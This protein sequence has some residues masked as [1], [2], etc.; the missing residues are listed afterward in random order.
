MLKAAPNKNVRGV[1]DEHQDAV[2]E[3]YARYGKVLKSAVGQVA[4]EEV[5][6]LVQNVFLNLY[7]EAVRETFDLRARTDLPRATGVRKMSEDC[8]MQP[9]I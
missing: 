5:D 8:G 9:L 6:D 4:K 1:T 2:T 3:L 7:R